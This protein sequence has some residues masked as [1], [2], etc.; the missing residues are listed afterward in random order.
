MLRSRLVRGPET[1]AVAKRFGEGRLPVSEQGKIACMG[2]QITITEIFKSSTSDKYWSVDVSVASFLY[3]KTG[4]DD[5]LQQV[6][7]R[8]VQGKSPLFTW[9]HVPEN[10]VS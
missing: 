4:I 10:N 5:I 3:G 1:N 8:K 9:I 2:S 6:R 7:P